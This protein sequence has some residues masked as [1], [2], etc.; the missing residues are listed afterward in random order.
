[1]HPFIENLTPLTDSELENKIS[2]ISKR[3]FM[4][5]NTYVREQILMV[6]STYKEEL[7]N[8]RSELWNKTMENTNKGLDKLINI[9]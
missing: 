4:T 6:L 7:E 8:R 1:V 2:E 3:Y 5:Q 9:N